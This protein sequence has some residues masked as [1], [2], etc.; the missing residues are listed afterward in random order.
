VEQ[1]RAGHRCSRESCRREVRA[2]PR[3][4]EQC[5]DNGIRRSA[6]GFP[7]GFASN[8]VSRSSQALRSTSAGQVFGPCLLEWIR[9]KT[10]L[11]FGCGH[12]LE[13][14]RRK[15]APALLWDAKVQVK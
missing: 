3:W 7:W 1:C 5:F 9:N 8:D 2:S 13:A 10:V 11:D 4:P 12:G 15:Q 14:T 6:D